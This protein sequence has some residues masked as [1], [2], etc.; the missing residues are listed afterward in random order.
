MI[1]IRIPNSISQIVVSKYTTLYNQRRKK[2]GKAYPRTALIDNIRSALSCNGAVVQPID[3][4]EPRVNKWKGLG[5]KVYHNNH[6]YYA[7]VLR[8]AANGTVKAIAKDALYDGDYHNDSLE[9]KPYES[10]QH[11]TISLTESDISWMVKETVRRLL[12]N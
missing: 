4:K 9:T 2:L 11:Q 7:V 5:Y 3:L 8:L 6:W 12:Y 10:K 1:E